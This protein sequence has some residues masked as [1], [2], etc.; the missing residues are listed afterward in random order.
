[1][2]KAKIAG[3]GR[4]LPERRVTSAALAAR[5]NVSEDWILRAA[6]V[7]ER[8]WVAGETSAEMGARAATEALAAAGIE[9]DQVDLILGASTVP[10]QGIPCTAVLIQ[11]ELG[12]AASRC[13]CCDVNATCLSGLYALQMAALMVDSGLYRAVLVVSSEIASPFIDASNPESFVLFGDGAGAL[14]VTRAEAGE[15]SALIHARFEAD[16]CGAELTTYRGGGSLYRPNDPTTPP[17]FNWF[18]MQGPAVFKMAARATE[19]FLNAFFVD[20]GATRDAVDAVVPHQASV[21]GL[22]LLTKRLGFRPGQVVATLQRYGNCGAASI[23][24]AL[25]EAIEQGRIRRGH[26]LLLAGTGAGFAIGAMLL[27]Y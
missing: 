21:H 25:A 9:A 20:A 22:E 19:P 27:T 26:R 12:I 16:S 3:A 2:L 5:L 15:E 8:R 7:C 24:I 1:M 10:Q 6:G 17:E 14:V 18:S 23:P 11:R 4:Y 13:A